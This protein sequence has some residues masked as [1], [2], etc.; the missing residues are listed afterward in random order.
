MCLWR[1]CGARA[2]RIIEET[3]SFE[4]QQIVDALMG[5]KT[6]LAQGNDRD[7]R[8]MTKRFARFL[9]QLEGIDTGL[10]EGS[11]E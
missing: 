4:R 9:D 7:I 11:Y 6:C 5:Y 3:L 10:S 2:E 1:C 8:I